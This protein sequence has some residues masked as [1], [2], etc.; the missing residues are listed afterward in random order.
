MYLNGWES[1]ALRT[2]V[3]KDVSA[4]VTDAEGESLC[5]AE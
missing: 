3:Y 5:K 4:T 2:V 1:L